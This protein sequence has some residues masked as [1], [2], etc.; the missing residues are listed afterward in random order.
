MPISRE[1]GT[2]NKMTMTPN[3]MQIRHLLKTQNYRALVLTD[4]V[5]EDQLIY[6]NYS[7]CR[8]TSQIKNMRNIVTINMPNVDMKDSQLVNFYTMLCNKVDHWNKRWT[9]YSHNKEYMTLKLNVYFYHFENMNFVYLLRNV[10]VSNITFGQAP[11]SFNDAHDVNITF[12]VTKKTK[13]HQYNNNPSEFSNFLKE[14][15]AM[16]F[17]RNLIQ[18][19]K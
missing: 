14:K 9:P 8:I 12:N 15:E 19:V 4:D 16:D 13:F 2:S 18:L 5:P 3:Q 1:F 17:Q 6:L 7:W 10:Y 11:Y